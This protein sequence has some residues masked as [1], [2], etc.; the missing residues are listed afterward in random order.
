MQFIT[1]YGYEDIVTA[2]IE[3]SSGSIWSIS[4]P[5]REQMRRELQNGSSDI[6]LRLTWTFQRYRWHHGGGGG[7]ALSAPPAHLTPLLLPTG[8]WAREGRWKTP[9][10]N[11]PL[12]WSPARP[13]ASSW[14]SCCRAPATPPCECPRGG[15]NTLDHPPHHAHWDGALPAHPTFFFLQASAQTL[16]QIHPGAQRS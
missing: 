14:P 11:T 9:S 7:A 16:P 8:T 4:P 3:G 13:N 12:T 1:L 15:D 10:T 5:S 6:T 2:H